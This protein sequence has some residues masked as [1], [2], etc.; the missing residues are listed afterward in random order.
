MLYDEFSC[1]RNGNKIPIVFQVTG[2]EDIVW[3]VALLDLNLLL[4]LRGRIY[5][6][7]VGEGAVGER[8]EGVE[9]RGQGYG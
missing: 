1:G 4:L 3:P 5:T 9:V 6:D 2:L 7:D 8:A